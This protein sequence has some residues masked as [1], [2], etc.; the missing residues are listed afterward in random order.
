MPVTVDAL[1]THLDYT[2]WATARLVHAA[3]LLTPQ[4]LTKDLGTADRSVLGTLVHVY[5][6]DRVWLGRILGNPPAA[7]IDPERDMH[8]PVLENDWPVLLDRWQDWASTLTDHSVTLKIPY[9]DLK[10][11]PY[12]TPA[13][14]IVLH[15]VNHA[16]HHRGQAAGFIRALGYV[17][18]P[19]DLI[20][21]YRQIAL[22]RTAQQG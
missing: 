19:L 11:N 3:G 2:R 6:A 7:F 15:V 5:A 18:P 12:E 9:K 10:G 14:Q 13:W 21:Y 1:R 8:M 4:E 17:P 22:Q 20:A 16:T